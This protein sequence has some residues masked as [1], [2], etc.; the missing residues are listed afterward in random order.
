MAD[1]VTFVMREVRL[2]SIADIGASG[3]TRDDGAALTGLAGTLS[4]YNSSGT[5]VFSGK[6]LSVSTYGQ[7]LPMADAI[8][9]VS[10]TSTGDVQSAGDYNMYVTVGDG[11][12]WQRTWLQ[13]VR[14]YSNTG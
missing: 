10:F 11:S 13:P 5:L 12:T 14:V 6:T 9:R 8:A 2:G 7:G 3:I 4:C 1:I